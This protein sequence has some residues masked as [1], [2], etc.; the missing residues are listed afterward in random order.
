VVLVGDD[1]GKLAD[2][3]TTGRWML[4]IIWQNILGFALVFNALAVVAASLGWISPVVA[5]VLH[6]VSSLTVVLNSL[7]LLVDPRR[8]RARLEGLRQK[9]ARRRRWLLAGASALAFTGY[10]L[11]G[12]HVVRVGEVA[13]VQR[14]GRIVRAHEPPG[15]HYR[16]PY[17]FGRHQTVRPSEVRRV[18]V[19]FR[20]IPGSFE[21]PPAYEWNV[22]HRGGRSE[23]RAEEAT[24]LA[25]D[26]NLVDVNLVVQYRVADPRA[27]LFRVGRRQGDGTSKWDA[28]VRAVAEAALRAEMSQQ[29]VEAVLGSQRAPIEEA[30]RR[31]LSAALDAYGAGFHVDTVRLG[32]VHPPVEVV[33]AFRD[34]TSARE[35]KEASINEAEAYEY[36]KEALARGEATKNV[37]DAQASGED[38]A[39]QARGDA[40]RFV[41]VAE[42]YAQQPEVTRLRLYLQA[43]ERSLAGRKKVI[44]DRVPPGARRQLFLGRAGLLGAFPPTQPEPL[45]ENAEAEG[46]PRP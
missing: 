7:R 13:V 30:I 17:P 22:Q 41:V 1:L 43:V 31:R 32:D 26:E 6:Q 39:K 34:V 10:L 45:Q 8:W 18:E 28:L 15:L 24:V 29:P 12:F 33:P 11:S 4:K 40:D 5:A 19:G 3:V 21:E 20:T 25:G 27:A 37:L 35:E 44:L 14:F 36:E 2:A 42:A 9:L 38:R 16:L 23:R 46:Y